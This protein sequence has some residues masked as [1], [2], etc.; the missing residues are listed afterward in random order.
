[1]FLIVLCFQQSTRQGG[2]HVLSC[3]PDFLLSSLCCRLLL[4]VLAVLAVLA[5]CM[6]SLLFSSSEKL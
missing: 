6:L 4:A 5:A 1:M 3:V 2:E